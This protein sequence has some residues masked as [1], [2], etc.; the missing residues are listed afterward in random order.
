MVSAAFQ[1]IAVCIWSFN[2]NVTKANSQGVGWTDTPVTDMSV[3][4][5]FVMLRNIFFW[6]LS[7]LAIIFTIIV[8]LL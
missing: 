3:V 4:W 1:E 6:K 8:K 7:K 5:L 2:I